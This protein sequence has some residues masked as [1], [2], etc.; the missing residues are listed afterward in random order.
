VTSYEREQSV[1]E[2][3]AMIS[4]RDQ[5]GSG[6]ASGVLSNATQQYTIADRGNKVDCD[7]APTKGV[8]APVSRFDGSISK[9]LKVKEMSIERNPVHYADFSDL[10]RGLILF[11]IRHLL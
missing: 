4:K 9:S 6:R 10:E 3:C 8:L 2:H 7:C 5:S 1:L 11:N